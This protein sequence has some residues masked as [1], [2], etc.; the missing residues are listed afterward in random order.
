VSEP[1]IVLAWAALALVHL[2]PAL[3]TFSPALRRRL[4]GIESDGALKVMLTHRGVLFAAVLVACV[5]AA[6][7]PEAR[8]LASLV[9]AISLIGFLIVYSASGAPK[10][11]L[12]NV[13]LVDAVAIIPLAIVCADAWL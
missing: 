3:A 4:Y 5:Y 6:M 9:V 7:A 11:P 13:A 10:G 2:M 12:R 1:W 8:Q